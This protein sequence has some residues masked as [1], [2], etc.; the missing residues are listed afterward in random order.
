MSGKAVLTFPK[1]IPPHLRYNG[2]VNTAQVQ[3]VRSFI[4]C[5]QR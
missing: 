2:A 1:W 3:L 4:T 5:E